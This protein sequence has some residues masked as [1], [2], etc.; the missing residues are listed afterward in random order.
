M[1]TWSIAIIA[2]FVTWSAVAAES[3]AQIRIGP[4]ARTQ[5]PPGSE[6]AGSTWIQFPVRVTNTSKGSIWLHGYSLHHPYTYLFTRRN[7]STPWTERVA[8]F[9]GIATNHELVSGAVTDF[10]VAVPETYV[11]EQLRVDLWVL[12][13][14]RDMKHV[15]V[16]S[17]ETPIK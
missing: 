5:A 10:T 3:P 2:S 11:G 7:D 15:T 1:K 14:P 9:C 17:Q 13:S 16:S 6:T 8:H 12:A 4:P